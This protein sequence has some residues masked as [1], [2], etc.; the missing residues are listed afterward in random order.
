M[1]VYILNDSCNTPKKAV[2]YPTVCS[3]SC[4]RL[5]RGGC[6]GCLP[7]L[8]T[9]WRFFFRYQ[10]WHIVLQRHSG[11]ISVHLQRCLLPLRKKITLGFQGKDS[12]DMKTYSKLCFLKNSLKLNKN[13]SIIF[14][15]SSKRVKVKKK[16]VK[17]SHLQDILNNGITFW[18]AIYLQLQNSS[19][20]FFLIGRKLIKKMLMHTYKTSNQTIGQSLWKEEVKCY[21]NKCIQTERRT[22]EQTFFV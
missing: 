6:W 10:K 7:G 1:H 3:L 22:L 8:P 18:H 13:T 16:G 14:C 4:N 21:N 9:R 19:K 11:L 5:W 12:V 17:P 2:T 20:F 15:Q